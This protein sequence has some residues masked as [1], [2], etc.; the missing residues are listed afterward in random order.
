MS[1]VLEHNFRVHFLK[2][3]ICYQHMWVGST[4]LQWRLVFISCDLFNDVVSSSYK[5]YIAPKCMVISE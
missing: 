4:P 2:M 3:V 5:A 1:T